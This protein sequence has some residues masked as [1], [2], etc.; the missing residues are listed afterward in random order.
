[1]LGFLQEME[2]RNIVIRKAVESAVSGEAT[3][4]VTGTKSS[5]RPAHG[6]IGMRL[7]EGRWV[8]VEEN[9]KN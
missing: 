4:T 2:P 6:E 9:W 1:M 8:L 7:F 3:L 5:G